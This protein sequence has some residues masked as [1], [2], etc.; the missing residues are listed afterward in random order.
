MAGPEQP[1]TTDGQVV[2]QDG[3]DWRWAATRDSWFPT[4][5]MPY[6]TVNSRV[7]QVWMYHPVLGDWLDPLHFPDETQPESDA[8]TSTLAATV[9][10]VARERD[11]G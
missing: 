1:G 4:D 8:A 3:R 10:K 11:G 9:R 2:T 6:E 5:P 7:G